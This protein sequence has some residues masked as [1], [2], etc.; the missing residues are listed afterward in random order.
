MKALVLFLTL[1][2]N[3][4]LFAQDINS[5]T[6]LTNKNTFLYLEVDELPQFQSDIFNTVMEY[7]YSNI[8]YPS[9][10][11]LQG[12]IIVSFVVTK[13]GDIANIKIEKSLFR[14]C[15]NEVTRVLLEMPKWTPGRKNDENVNTLLFLRVDFT[16]Y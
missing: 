14:E 8:E 9:Q 4:A 13:F 3:T 1:F 6:Y 10:I 15:D 7:I 11:D 12:S 16:I 5:D 2:I